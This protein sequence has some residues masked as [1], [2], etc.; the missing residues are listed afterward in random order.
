MSKSNE[1]ILSE[2]QRRI[3]AACWEMILRKDYI[4]SPI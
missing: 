2:K 1:A 3:F 4:L